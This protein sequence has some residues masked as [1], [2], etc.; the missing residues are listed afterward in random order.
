MSYDVVVVG[1]GI[2]GLTV[3]ALLA[4]RGESVCLLERQSQVGGCVGRINF[5]GH[6]FEPGM[7]LYSGWGQDEIHQRVFSE[8]PVSAPEA[9]ALDVPYVVRLPDKTDV[10]LSNEDATFFPELT[11]A[12]PECAPQAVTFYERAG[13]LATAW[14]QVLSDFPD[15][16]FDSP[17]TIRT[18]L[19]GGGALREV[20]RARSQ[21]AL[22]QLAN[23]SDRFQTF[24]AAQLGAFAHTALHE[25]ALLPASTALMSLRGPH[26][27]LRG[28]IA[29]LAECLA[30]SIKRSG[31]TVRLDTPVLR[32][33]YNESAEAIGVD[34]L[35]GE[36]VVA[37]QAI[38]SNMTIWDTYGK[39]IGLNHTPGE[40]KKQLAQLRG[41]GA[42][43]IYAS[44]EAPAAARLPAPHFLVASTW[45]NAEVDE[46]GEQEFTFATSSGSSPPGKQ[47]VTIKTG[48]AVEPW[49]RYQSSEE[50]AGQWDQQA[51]ESLW[52]RLHRHVPELGADIEVLETAN[53]R[54][55][56]DLT[57]RKLGM[58]LGIEQT[59]AT[60]L[61]TVNTTSLP[62]VFMVGDTV[63]GVADVASVTESALTLANTL[64]LPAQHL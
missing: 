34:L 38:I 12:F 9:F 1:G 31:G 49:F 41:A 22:D 42:Y 18:F 20:A 24:I 11:Q 44:Q 29:K 35:S 19:P 4:A 58:V 57:R 17:K 39:L 40:V 32:V 60:Q 55:F 48:T 63:S 30:E 37:R 61:T 56:Y 50:D 15:F 64:K 54:T 45:S 27:S 7:G 13:K 21:T 28:G 10:K 6:D 43:L 47:A 33:A 5:S 53:P 25:C 52:E 46:E 26:Y 36:T 16:S 14:Q 59:S 23:T 51:L 62:N 3:A 8:L 2:G